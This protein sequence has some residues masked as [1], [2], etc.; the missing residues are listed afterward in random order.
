ME[1]FAF[2]HFHTHP[3]PY[4]EK[5]KADIPANFDEQGNIRIPVKLI[6]LCRERNVSL[7]LDSG[8]SGNITCPISLACAIGLKPQGVGSVQLADGSII[9][10]PIFLGKVKIGDKIIDTT[11]LVLSEES[12]ECLVGMELLAPYKITFHADKKEVSINDEKQSFIKNKHIQDLQ[13]SLRKIIPR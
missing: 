8:F 12:K 11:Y 9:T 6:G 3:Y 2:G 10:L 5:M 13:K 1:Y 7:I 4:N